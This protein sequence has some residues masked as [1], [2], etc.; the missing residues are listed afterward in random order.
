MS[1]PTFKLDPASGVPFYRQIQD[2]ILAAVATKGLAPGDRLP[3]VRALA[4]ELSINPNTVA[5]AYRDLEIR[6]VLTT[7]QGSGSFISAQPVERDGVEAR[8][9]TV[10]LVDEFLARAAGLGVT[11]DEIRRELDERQNLATNSGLT[12]SDKSNKRGE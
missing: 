9:R 1:Q 8:R 11:V 4:V 3:T 2:Q 7:Q 5:R 10:Q 12:E 6:G